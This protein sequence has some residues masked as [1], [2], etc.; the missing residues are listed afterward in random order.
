MLNLGTSSSRTIET[1]TTGITAAQRQK[2]YRAKRIEL[3]GLTRYQEFRNRENARLQK[4][5][6]AIYSCIFNGFLQLYITNLIWLVRIKI[7]ICMNCNIKNV[8]KVLGLGLATLITTKNICF[9][10]S[11]NLYWH[12]YIY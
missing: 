4:Y 6:V 2:E 11:N 3:L 7:H 8:V 5:K 1:Q 12:A 9:I 10:F